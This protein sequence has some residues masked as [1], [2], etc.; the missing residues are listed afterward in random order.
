M[1]LVG[2]FDHEREC[3]SQVDGGRFL[4]E[5]AP[6]CFLLLDLG[7]KE[8]AVFGLRGH[9]RSDIKKHAIWT[10]PLFEP[11]LTWLRNQFAQGVTLSDLPALVDLPGNEATESHRHEGP[12]DALVKAALKSPDKE[13]QAA[14]RAVWTATYGGPPPGTPLTLAEARQWLGETNR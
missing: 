3:T 9:A 8:G 12:M 13:V 5:E 4:R 2:H 6:G 11:M 1:F 7:T 14:A 10:S